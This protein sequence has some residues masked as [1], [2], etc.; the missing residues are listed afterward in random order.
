MK[1]L[2][3]ALFFLSGAAAA[4]DVETAGLKIGH[5]YA[6][7]TPPTAMSGAGYLTI[8]NEGD[9]P[10][11]LL[12]VRA[13]FPSVT[14]HRTEV[15][16][17]GVARMRPVDGIDIA[18]GETATLEPGGMH[19][20][21]MGLEG[22]PFEAGDVIPATLVFEKAGEVP[23]EFW[24]QPRGAAP[25]GHEPAPDAHGGMDHGADQGGAAGSYI[26][27]DTLDFTYEFLRFIAAPEK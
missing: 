4:H 24:V 22:D 15:G 6:I 9:A 16:A 7:E 17:D 14:L 5:P 23:I 25:V 19:V 20:I 10:D 26:K 13:D 11:R 3:L 1:P 12:A 2:L 18:P 8:A 27:K 21:F